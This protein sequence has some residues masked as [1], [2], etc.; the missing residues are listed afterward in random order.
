M[1]MKKNIVFS[2]VVIACLVTFGS[3]EDIFTTSIFQG[4][5]KDVSKMSA[6]ELRAHAEGLQG[7]GTAKDMAKAFEALKDKLPADPADD[8][9]LCLLA[10]DMALGGSGL[11][12][13]ITDVLQKVVAGDPLDDTLY[14]D[15]IGKLDLAMMEDMTDLFSEIDNAAAGSISSHQYATAAVALLVLIVD[16]VGVA[17]ANG[18]HSDWDTV[19]GWATKANIDI[20]DFL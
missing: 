15:V 1:V 19:T 20:N 12:D 3:C 18:G 2:L 13:A 8:P 16:D 10:C 17:G 14:T 6:A 9:E 7:A 11:N 5:Q 4:L